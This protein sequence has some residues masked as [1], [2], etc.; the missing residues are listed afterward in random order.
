MECLYLEPRAPL[1]YEPQSSEEKSAGRRRS[2]PRL[3]HTPS[4]GNDLFPVIYNDKREP[5]VPETKQRR[6]MELR[7][8]QHTLLRLNIATRAD[9]SPD[10]INVWQNLMPKLALEFDNVLYAVFTLSATHML[11][12]S[13]HEDAVYRAR[14]NYFVLAL[15]EQRQA[16]DNM[17]THTI[18]A[19][20]ITAILILLAAFAMLQERTL[21]EYTPPMDWIQMGRGVNAVMWRTSTAVPQYTSSIHQLVLESIPVLG[22]D[23][24]VSN[25]LPH[26]FSDILN[27]DDGTPDYWNQ[28]TTDVY[29]RTLHV[30]ASAQDAI[31]NDEP[32]YIVG[33]R[34]QAFPIVI[35]ERFTDFVKDRQPRAL[36]VLA[37][38]FGVM[39]QV[40]TDV[41][42][43][44]AHSLTSE[45]IAYREIR[46]I[47][48]FLPGD[49]HDLMEWPLS[50]I[51]RQ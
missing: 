12:N 8:M 28:N 34:I 50:M 51:A 24:D 42:F 25:P 40:K 49:W 19:V 32:Q 7:L 31:N 29:E 17:N 30:I 15:R 46:A 48:D 10:W 16:I 38:Y 47:A 20:C 36:V 6:M 33:R 14:Q 43:T 37:H 21:T 39:A 13:G 5:E 45:R 26:P 2:R 1:I 4:P 9:I 11:Q 18:D 3:R 27:F 23:I 41:W 35:P 44:E 22:T